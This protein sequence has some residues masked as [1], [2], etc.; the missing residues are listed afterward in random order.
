M[1][2]V[3]LLLAALAGAMAA[4]AFGGEFG[5]S[6]I[7]V[8]LDRGVKSALVTVTNDDRKPLAFQVRALEWT[9]DAAGADRYAQ[10]ADL[11][12]FPRQLKI[13]PGESRVIRVGYK[14]PAT[15]RESTYRLYIEEL[16]DPGTRDSGQTG[17]SVTLRFG[18]PVFVRPANPLAAGVIDFADGA[19]RAVV[20]NTG[21]VHFRVAA[22]RYSGIGPGGETTFEHSVDG[23]YVLAGA[24]RAF[25]LK[26]PPEACARTRRLRAEAVVEKLDLRAE[27]ALGPED[28]R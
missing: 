10:T 19:A 11:V 3:R 25:A 12:Y 17:V 6:P 20:R 13:P 27:R 22:L 28:C 7:R 15:Q 5:V 16:A 18:V 21:N 14:A 9:Q 23:W 1:R 24:Q 26:L 2:L 4:A 8:E